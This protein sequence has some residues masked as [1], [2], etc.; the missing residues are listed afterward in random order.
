MTSRNAENLLAPKPIATVELVRRLAYRPAEA[1]QALGVGETKLAELLRKGLPHV[2]TGGIILIPVGAVEDWLAEQA[3][4]QQA[5]R[6]QVPP[7]GDGS[8]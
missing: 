7:P 8:L 4:A 1:A 5:K 6:A 2:R 3:E